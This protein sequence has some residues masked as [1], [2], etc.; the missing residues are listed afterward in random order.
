M[1]AKSYVFT[2]QSSFLIHAI[3]IL[4][5][6]A[7]QSHFAEFL[8]GSS[9]LTFVFSTC[10]LV[11]DWYSLSDVVA[12]PDSLHYIFPSFFPFQATSLRGC[13]FYSLSFRSLYLFPLSRSSTA[14]SSLILRSLFFVTHTCIVTFVSLRIVLLPLHALFR[15]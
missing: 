10:S 13:F 1:L 14:L 11:S 3:S 8:K 4:F 6:V 15:C 12:F 9:S 7:L 2:K 5:L